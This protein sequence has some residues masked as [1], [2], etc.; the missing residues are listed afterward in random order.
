MSAD[1]NEVSL[2]DWKRR[3]SE[4]YARVRRSPQPQEA[5]REWRDERDRLF[6]E[7]PQSP[8][9][10]ER[11]PTF[12]GLP[13]FDYDPALRVVG[14]LAPTE[15]EELEITTSRD[16]PISFVRFAEASFDLWGDRHTLSLFWVEAYGGGAFLS[17]RDE[18]SGETTYGA[19][20][21]LLDTIK[22]ADLGDDAG[23]LVLD[24][25]FAYNPSCSYDPRWACPLAP[26]ENRLTVPVEG[27]ERYP[28]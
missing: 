17:F 28:I 23:G 19:G 16:G 10:L 7:H 21:Y 14:A 5:W 2:L 25:N 26:P 6:K 1:I 9:P 15:R 24:F 8:I 11:R 18:T 3:V 4:L 20:R 12:E 27:G 22:G 13:Y